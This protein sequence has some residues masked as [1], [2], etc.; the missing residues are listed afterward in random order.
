MF[1]SNASRRDFLKKTAYVTPLILTM[2]VSLAQ[3]QAGSAAPVE[4]IDGFDRIE[5]FSAGGSH[6]ASVGTGADSSPR[7]ER[8][9]S[10]WSGEYKGLNRGKHKGWYKDGYKWLEE[11]EAHQA[12]V[13]D[14]H[15]D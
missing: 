1:E 6:A 7:V 15:D 5:G 4:R 12:R 14:R 3:A 10:G 9:S 8:G 11:R 2:N 13:L